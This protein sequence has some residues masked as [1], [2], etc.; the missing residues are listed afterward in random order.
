MQP[1]RILLVEDNPD[2]EVLV[3]REIRRGGY[4]VTHKRVETAAAMADALATEDWDIIISDF[5]L[6]SFNAPEAVQVLK[7]S[8][9]DIP[10]IIV[11]GTVGEDTAVAALKAG[12]HD[13]LSKNG[14]RRLLPAIDRELREARSRNARRQDQARLRESEE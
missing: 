10:I 11:S 7:S 4:D 9:R 5:S 2:D 6:P 3:L 1:L 14:M 13:F 12:A 8:G